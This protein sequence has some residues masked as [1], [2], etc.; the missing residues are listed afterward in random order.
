MGDR[1][2]LTEAL[3]GMAAYYAQEGNLAVCD[4]QIGTL[5]LSPG[6]DGLTALTENFGPQRAAQFES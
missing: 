5:V 4:L 6:T 1:A 2:T 3:L